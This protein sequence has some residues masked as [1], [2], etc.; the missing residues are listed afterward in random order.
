MLLTPMGGSIARD[1]VSGA[2]SAGNQ[3]IRDD[4]FMSEV[5]RD[6]GSAIS[7]EAKILE[8]LPGGAPTKRTKLVRVL[9][10]GN[11]AVPDRG[12]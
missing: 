9:Q 12:G 7:R 4:S 5:G 3:A 8:G 6:G 10:A 11:R 2:E 1:E